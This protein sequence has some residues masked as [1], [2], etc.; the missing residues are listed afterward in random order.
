MMTQT[1]M[2]IQPSNIMFLAMSPKSMTCSMTWLCAFG[3][4]AF[5]FAER[6]GALGGITGALVDGRELDP[7]GG[8]GGFGDGEFVELAGEAAVAAASASR[9][10]ERG[11]RAGEG[12]IEAGV[13][14][15]VEEELQGLAIRDDARWLQVP[16]ATGAPGWLRGGTVI[17]TTGTPWSS[18]R[19]KS[20]AVGAAED[21]GIVLE[22]G[23]L[24][25]S[26]NGQR[27]AG[28]PFERGGVREW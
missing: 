17:S 13:G 28:F 18:S 6:E 12:A 10:G 16:A 22:G 5:D 4:A 14:C 23:G 9:R 15:A 7:A 24:D 1:P 2:A 11:V 26:G 8:A 3:L 27:L 21:D 20:S 19:R 25:P